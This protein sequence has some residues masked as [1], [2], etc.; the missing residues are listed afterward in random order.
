MM[1]DDI[2]AGSERVFA[3]G[4][5]VCVL[6]VFTKKIINP[7]QRHAAM[8]NCNSLFFRQYLYERT[9][10]CKHRR[11]LNHDVTIVEGSVADHHHDGITHGPN[12]CLQYEDKT[13]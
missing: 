8:N 6:V 10:Y 1:D 12:P 5:H 3:S 2:I 9:P 11:L 4:P 13:W 7:T